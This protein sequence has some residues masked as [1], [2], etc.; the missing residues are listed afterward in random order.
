M[1]KEY[2]NIFKGYQ[3]R[4]CNYLSDKPNDKIEFD[5]VKWVEP[6]DNKPYCYSV[7]FLIYNK[8]ECYFELKSVG[9][10]WLEECPDRDVA[11]WIKYWCLHKEIEIEA[12]F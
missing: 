2:T 10:R 6:V 1:V 9:L 3:I 11:Y 4:E 5:I 8:K 7:A 12:Q